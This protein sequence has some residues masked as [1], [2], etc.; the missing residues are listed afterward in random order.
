[1]AAD[2]LAEPPSVA[3]VLSKLETL[4]RR[5]R[6]VKT[7][8]TVD[9]PLSPADVGHETASLY[10]GVFSEESESHR[11]AIVE[12]AARKIFYDA[13]PSI[14]IWDPEFVRVWDLFDILAILG[15]QGTCDT[16]LV[17]WLI[18]E[19]L[20]SQTTE[21]CRVVLDY[22]ESRGERLLQKDFHKTHLIILRACNELLRRLSRAEDAV[23]C[24]RVFFFLFQNFPLGDKSSVNL[25]GEFHE[26]NVTSYETPLPSEP[27]ADTEK[28]EVDGSQPNAKLR[29]STPA[30]R[31]PKAHPKGPHEDSAV[32]T[33]EFYPIFWRMQEDFANPTRL[34]EGSNLTTF[35]NGLERT[36]LEFGETPVVV[37]TKVVGEPQ[38][39]TKR[40]FGDEGVD[41]FAGNYNPKYLTSRDLFE[42]EL[43]DLAFQR[44]I[45]VQA[46]IL[47]D[48]L[49]SLTEK[50]KKKLADPSINNKALLYPYTL[51]DKD[52]D[53]AISMRSKIATYI[54]NGPEGQ[55][56]YRM[57]D[58]VLSRDKNWV[59][60]KQE[61]C[62]PIVRDAVTAEQYQGAQNAAR[63]ATKTRNVRGGAGALDLT[64]LSEADSMNNLELLKDSARYKA[65]SIEQLVKGIEGDDLDLEMAMTDEET[66]SLQ[67]AKSS[68]TWRA[69]RLAARTTLSKLDKVE[70]GKSLPEIFKDE[71]KPEEKVE[72]KAEEALP[73]TP[74]EGNEISAVEETPSEVPVTT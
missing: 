40:K 61:S 48:F 63:R 56:Y 44:H 26:A 33:S 11:F 16:S 35:R 24:G 4:L 3:A 55:F 13:V 22:L 51:S 27:T 20:D 67:A 46:L 64:F 36:L 29:D 17:F 31:S 28:M 73:K 15:A 70:T 57:V 43:S 1:M 6:E 50:A 60:W 10:E 38:Q 52:R 39:G 9:P 54:R 42:L 74:A 59:R 65:P 69:L 71:E 32:E 68:K 49:L 34:F 47:L 14:S 30:N 2:A 62:P 72:E 23:L 41:H 66:Q 53:W 45:L 37:Q 25:R 5:A 18:E 21:G 7:A 12:T 8:T 58:T 19:L